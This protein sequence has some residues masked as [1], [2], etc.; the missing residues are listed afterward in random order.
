MF[1]AYSAGAADARHTARRIP[2][3][4]IHHDFIAFGFRNRPSYL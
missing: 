1:R 3:R 4:L 2:D